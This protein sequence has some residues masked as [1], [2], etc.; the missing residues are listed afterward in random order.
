MKVRVKFFATFR[1]LFGA[2][3][4]EVELDKGAGV[5]ELLAAL[6]D[7]NKCRQKIFDESGKIRRDVKMLKKGRHIQLLDELHSELEDGDVVSV[8]PPLF[9]G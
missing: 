7:S 1:E 5:G 2:E 4:R 8:F 9:G 3:E 6:C